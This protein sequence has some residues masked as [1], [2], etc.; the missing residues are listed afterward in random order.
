[1][2]VHFGGVEESPNGL[3]EVVSD[4]ALNVG[5]KNDSVASDKENIDLDLNGPL[6]VQNGK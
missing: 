1:M 3:K 2:L 5:K 4:E 6:I